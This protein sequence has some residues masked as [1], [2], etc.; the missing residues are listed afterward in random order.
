MA[1]DVCVGYDSMMLL[2]R[3]F[4]IVYLQNLGWAKQLDFMGHNAYAIL[5]NMYANVRLY[6]INLIIFGLKVVLLI[7]TK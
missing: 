2:C 6:S 3:H 1:S 4:T 5:F 7:Y